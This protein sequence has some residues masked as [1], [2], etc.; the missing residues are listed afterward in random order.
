[1]LRTFMISA[2]AAVLFAGAW[3]VDLVRYHPANDGLNPLT[4][5]SLNLGWKQ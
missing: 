1:M 2:A 4:P 5:I 3:T